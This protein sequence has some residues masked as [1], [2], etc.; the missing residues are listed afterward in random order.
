MGRFSQAIAEGDGISV[1]P[2]LEGDVAELAALAEEAGAEAVA[3]QSAD[4]AE[5][6]RAQ[7]ALPILVRGPLREA[8][9]R[10]LPARGADACVVVFREV[11]DEE[12][13]AFIYALAREAGLDCAVEVREEEELEE[14]LELVD[15]EILVISERESNDDEEDLERTLD[16]LSDVPAGKLVV[17]QSPIR[18]REQVVALERAGVDAIL[19]G[20]EFL[21]V[22]PDFGSALAELT[23]R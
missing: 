14:A 19:V 9:V 23:G 3:V 5:R 7:T 4:E 8:D 1:V 21:R 12:R 6:A 16:L 13:L 11:D 10:T 17:A 2:M 22:S 20:G 15:P 18:T